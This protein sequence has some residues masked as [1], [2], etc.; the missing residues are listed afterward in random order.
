MNILYLHSH[1]T[2]RYIR[3]YGHDLPTPHLQSLADSGMLFRQAHCAAPTCS[4]SR[5]ALLTGE[6]AHQSGMVGL[7]HRGARLLHPERHLAAFL[8]RH[9]FETVHA[10]LSHLGDVALCGYTRQSGID[11]I[12][13]DA[14]AEYAVNYLRTADRKRPFFLD[15]GFFETHRTDTDGFSLPGHSPGDGDG[16]S[17]RALPPP[18]L[19]DHPDTRR[20][21]QDY[22]HSVARLDALH[23]RVLAELDAAGLAEDTLVLATTDHGVAF[24]HYKCG[25]TG[26]GTGVLFIL[27]APRRFAGGRVSDALVSHLDFFPTVCDLLGLD[28]PPWL[29]GR[30]LAPLL[31]GHTKT[32]HEALFSEVTFHAAFEPK[33]GVRTAR[34]NYI[35]NFA[36]PHPPV[37]ANCDDGLSK[38]LLLEHGL[39]DRI[40]P[41]EEL[42]DLFFDPQ[43]RNNLAAVPAHAHV[44]AEMRERLAAWMRRTAD[45]LLDDTPAALHLPHLVNPP[46]ARPGEGRP[47]PW[48]PAGWTLLHR[49]ERD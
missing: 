40:T 3:P 22:I 44:L 47:A 5:A 7:A 6:T 16:D 1:D 27:R 23:G 10:G 17:S 31:E 25:L 33:R 34:W 41:H 20:D 9:G 37:L 43:E 19:P 46:H 26:L 38:S 4:P 48:D 42:Y 11:P 15:V 30:S 13:G 2:G 14:V 35:C 24:P 28:P 32:H 12:N 18:A 21:W 39:A 36:A 49:P 8:A 45:P 29:L